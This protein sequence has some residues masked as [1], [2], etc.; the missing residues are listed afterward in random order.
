MNAQILSWHLVKI[1]NLLIVVI[2]VICKQNENP[3]GSL[4][5]ISDY[6]FTKALMILLSMNVKEIVI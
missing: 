1:T 6:L 3:P 2:I 4:R 5:F